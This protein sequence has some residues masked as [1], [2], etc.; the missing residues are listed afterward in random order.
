MNRYLKKILILTVALAMVLTLCS[1]FG[2]AEEKSS[3]SG[4]LVVKDYSITDVKGNPVSLITK[5]QTVNIT[6]YMK[7]TTRNAYGLN[8]NDN[9][10]IDRRADSFSGGQVSVTYINSAGLLEMTVQ[11][12][13][14]KYKGTGNTLKLLA[15][16]WGSPG[17]QDYVDVSITECKEYEEPT[18]EPT[19][20]STPDP[21]PAPKAIISRSELASSIKANQ[22]ITVTV[23]VKN[24]GSTTMQSPVI[25]F[26]PSD[27]LMLPGSSSM[28]QLKNIAPGKTESVDV[29][30]RALG[31]ITGANQSLDATLTFDYFNRV[32]TVSG[33]S[34]GKIIIPAKV[35]KTD[36]ESQEDATVDSPVPNIIITGFDY[37]GE[38]VAAGSAF[39]LN[40]KFMNTN[41]KLSVE[42]LVVT[43]DGGEGFAINGSTNT[44]YFDKIKPG[45]TKQ[46]HV[47]M[48]ALN[49]LTNGVQPV[50]ASFK[51]EYVDHQK[52]S[53][54]TSDLK[55]SIPVY[56][57]D[58]FEITK[59]T[60]PVVVYAGEETSLSLNY[61][62][63]SKGEISNVEASIEGDVD[64]AAPVQNIG[65]LE[66]GK[67]GTIAFAVT[68]SEPGETRFTIKV[69]YEDGNGTVKTR[70][71]PVVMNVEEMEPIDPG[72]D[73]PMPEEDEG[74]GVK[75]PII[76]G[77]A[78]LALIA[79]LLI[80]KKK[81]KAAAARKEAEMWDNWDDDEDISGKTDGAPAVEDKK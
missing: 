66:A 17:Q 2:F 10:T 48:K 45:K 76:I 8:D 81:K 1:A 67:S 64:T 57:P 71:F 13:G 44:F 49:T 58:K 20:P 65:N 34:E 54:V 19:E 27:S 4:E 79:A 55:V 40:I 11:I 47:P 15:G 18:Y 5:G 80:I 23:Y 53:S 60:V 74:G 59:P 32:S 3:D 62:N 77:I 75:W 22:E 6:L 7:H 9:M 68:P 52:R 26:T 16:Y 46:I 38:S 37:G 51:Y 39:G 78:V 61:V 31:T 43:I 36:D 29:R 35:K 42:N 24:I 50:T 69:T 21:L 30:V 73:E 33:S 12:K 41:R 25:Q 72:M 63:K 70:V 28:M 14:L 56:Q